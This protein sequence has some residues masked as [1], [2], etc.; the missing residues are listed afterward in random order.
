MNR[1]S[2]ITSPVQESANGPGSRRSA[3]RA[4]PI[5]M[6][7]ILILFLALAVR[8]Y[9]LDGQSIWSD[10]GLSIQRT[11]QPFPA[12]LANTITLDGIE[13]R[14]TNP[15]LYF[16]SL[17]MWRLGLGESIFALRYLSVLVGVLSV[18]L[19][20]QLGR[21]SFNRRVGVAAALVLALSPFHVWMSQEIRNYTLLIFLNLLSVY[22]LFRYAVEQG[23]AGS[24]RW[25]LLWGAAGVTGIYTHFFGALIFGYGAL[26]LIWLWAGRL[27]RE[28]KWRPSRGLAIILIIV[29]LISLPILWTG[30]SRFRVEQQIDFVFVPIQHLVSHA[31]SAYSV[32]LIQTFVQPLWR[33]LPAVLLAIIGIIAGWIYTRQ[34]RRRFTLWL[35][36]GYLLLPFLFLFFLS[37]ISPIYNGP[38]HLL[39]GLP[40]FL[41][42]VATGLVLPWTIPDAGEAV[43]QGQLVRVQPRIWQGIVVILGIWLVVSQAHWLR[44]QFTSDALIKDDFRGLAAYLSQVAEEDDLIIL[45]DTISSPIFDYYYAGQAD[46][47]AIPAFWQ[48]DPQ[49]ALADLKAAGANAKR[50]WFVTQPEPR[51]GFPRKTL[52]QWAE[53]NWPTFSSRWFPWLWLRIR[54][55]GYTPEPII[56]QLP[57][58][59]T[60][61]E[62]RLGEELT[63]WGVD[64][65]ETGRA[66]SYW[67]PTL[68]WS[69][70]IVDSEGYRLSFRLTDQSGNTWAQADQP[71]WRLF[72]PNQWPEGKLVRYQPIIKLPAGLPPGKYNARLRVNRTSDMQPL[73][74]DGDV[75]IELTPSLVIE[76]ATYPE[77][78]MALPEHTAVH[79]TLGGQI[80]VVGYSIS[81]DEFKPGHPATVEVLWRVKRSPAKDYI[82]LTQLLNAQG[83]VISESKGAPSRSDYPTSSWVKGE[84]LAGQSHLAIPATAGAGAHSVRL[85]LLDPDSMEPIRAGWLPGRDY[86][87]L[88]DLLVTPWPLETELPSIPVNFRADFGQPPAIELHGYQL[89]QPDGGAIDGVSPGDNL[90]LTLFWR[91]LSDSM[92]TNYSVLVHLTEATGEIIAQGDGQPVNG[93]R[94]TTSWRQGEVIVDTHHLAIPADLANGSY[95]LWIGLYDPDTFQRLPAAVGTRSEADGRVLLE[96]IQVNP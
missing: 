75:E 17:R 26:A 65:P 5:W 10:E 86:V 81:G 90:A 54:L 4:W 15:P 62:Q 45:H 24:W 35:I 6:A 42:L 52:S 87:N 23:K 18:A 32:G 20:Y 96:R 79:A 47:T 74:V 9:A 1:A 13:S 12:I 21:L 93:F 70:G 46:W 3:G 2:G 89:A 27:R 82:L 11:S 34:Y 51:T 41:L 84:Y 31:L 94:P 16:L 56:D 7:M 25:L 72:P 83:E 53:Q 36:L 8:V 48:Q 92:T 68:Y 67:Q 73:L 76:A 30:F 78:Q 85:A 55:V 77:D 50:I 80:E 59:A 44:A 58:G 14:D 61:L 19:F 29:I 63:L 64:V 22:G 28:E 69:R 91:S 39:T 95:D 60:P 57:A 43:G 66:G 71:L 33:V 88:G 38:R 37:T 40:P 49:A